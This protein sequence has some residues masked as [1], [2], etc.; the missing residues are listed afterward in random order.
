MCLCVSVNINVWG[1]LYV[2]VLECYVCV[3]H[4][5]CVYVGASCEYVLGVLCKYVW[6]VVYV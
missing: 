5:V 6:G 4:V 1:V 3:G 2:Y